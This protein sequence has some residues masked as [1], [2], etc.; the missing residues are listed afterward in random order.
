MDTD[1]EGLSKTFHAQPSCRFAIAKAGR[2]ALHTYIRGTGFRLIGCRQRYDSL[3]N[4]GIGSGRS[5]A[6]VRVLISL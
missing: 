3:Q 1:L 2:S 4:V 5:F 6:R